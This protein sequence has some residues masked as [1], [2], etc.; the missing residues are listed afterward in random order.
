MKSLYKY[1]DAMMLYIKYLKD[2]GIDP[3]EVISKSI[4]DNL[5]YLLSFLDSQGIYCLVDNYTTIVY[6]DGTNQKAID[7]IKM[8]RT[9]YIINERN[10]AKYKDVIVNYSHC[11]DKA[12]EYIH[13]P[14]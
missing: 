7:Y 9:I 11:I 5:G 14:F 12:F 6:T 4:Q 10:T 2:K 8:T 1:K 13:Y 3:K